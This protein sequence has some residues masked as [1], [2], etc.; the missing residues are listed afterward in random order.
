MTPM[1]FSARGRPVEPAVICW[2]RG[3]EFCSATLMRV[4]F[5]TIHGRSMDRKIT[6]IV[7]LD[8]YFI[9]YIYSVTFCWEFSPLP[10]PFLY[11]VEEGER[12]CCLKETPISSV[13]SLGS[14]LFMQL[15]RASFRLTKPESPVRDPGVIHQAVHKWS[16][17]FQADSLSF[18]G[19]V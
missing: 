15:Q 1:I 13:L 2:S 6:G 9:Q 18:H 17:T 3:N 19:I 5:N 8:T 14:I 10:V 11:S 7:K 4:K 16:E 12:R